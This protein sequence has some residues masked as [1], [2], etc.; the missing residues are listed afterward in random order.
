[1][2]LINKILVLVRRALEME[3][4]NWVQEAQGM[5]IQ[6]YKSLSTQ[7]ATPSTIGH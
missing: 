3:G 6:E 4:H 1:M 7:M 5:E 2:L